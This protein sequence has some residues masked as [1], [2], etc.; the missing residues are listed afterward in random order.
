MTW[1]GASDASPM[2]R[3]AALAPSLQP[4]E[5]RVAEVIASDVARAVDMT[6]Q[7]LAEV[8]SVGRATVVRTAQALGYGGY[9]QLRVALARQRAIDTVPVV[10][11]EG[12]LGVVRT[13]MDNF[14]R[15]VPHMAATLTADV[16]DACVNALDTATRVVVS[17]NGLSAP[18]G[19]DVA[20]RLTAAGRPIEYLPDALAQRIA[21]S[22]LDESCVLLAISGSGAHRSTLDAVDA[23][24]ASGATVVAVTGFARSALV[25][26]ATIAVIVPPVSES[27]QDELVHTSR[28]AMTLVVEAL[29]EALVV[30]RGPRARDA[31]A[32]ALSVVSDSLRE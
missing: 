7:E 4:S 24:A 19:F 25:S 23:A 22:H 20:L 12:N 10:S 5:R 21:A 31:R 30:Q 26:R 3:I 28:A 1:T 2:A 14:A 17:A 13:M 29:V 15:A 9:P 11:D 32:A 16:V 27:F 18:L 6:A 8:A